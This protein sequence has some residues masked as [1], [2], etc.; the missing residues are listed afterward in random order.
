MNLELFIIGKA[1]GATNYKWSI[2]LYSK[3]HN[4]VLSIIKTA[5]I[6]L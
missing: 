4:L 1:Y 3:H 6:G 2:V 5:E